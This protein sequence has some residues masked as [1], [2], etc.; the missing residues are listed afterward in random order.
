MSEGVPCSDTGGVKPMTIGGRMVRE[1]ERCIG[2][3]PEERAWRAQY[4]KD[5]ILTEREPV[6]VK[7]LHQQFRNPLR[8]WYMKPLDNLLLEP[9]IPR[10]V[11]ISF[12]RNFLRM[13][14]M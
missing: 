11:N 3:T 5:Q 6:F 14:I 7:E 1:R 8:R 4:L 10:I 13:F 2:M 9:L 12:D